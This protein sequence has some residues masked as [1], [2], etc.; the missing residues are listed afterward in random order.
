MG[1]LFPRSAEVK[2]I[3]LGFF[4]NSHANGNNMK[5]P[6]KRRGFKELNLEVKK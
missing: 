1:F 6:Q 3:F 4:V 5:A 2:A